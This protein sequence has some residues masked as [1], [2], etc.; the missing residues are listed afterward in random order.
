MLYLFSYFNDLNGKIKYNMTLK[1]MNPYH[2]YAY[3]YLRRETDTQIVQL[4][5]YYIAIYI[6]NILPLLGG[7]LQ[8]CCC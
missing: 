8:L 4:L 5:K 1:Y 7:L 2:Q 6:Y 3:C